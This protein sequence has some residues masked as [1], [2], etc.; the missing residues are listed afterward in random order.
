M[1][2]IVDQAACTGCGLCIEICPQ[3]FGWEEEKAVAT[4][5]PV[6]WEYEDTCQDASDRCPTV[7]IIIEG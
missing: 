7:A 6:A 3:V 5:D 1:R 4:M 2:A